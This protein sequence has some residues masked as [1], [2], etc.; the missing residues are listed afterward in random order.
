MYTTLSFAIT[1]GK[2]DGMNGAVYLL[3]PLESADRRTSVALLVRERND[4]NGAVASFVS[5]LRAIVLSA[6]Y[7]PVY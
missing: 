1:T 6:P 4:R 2:S 5:G 3:A 7:L